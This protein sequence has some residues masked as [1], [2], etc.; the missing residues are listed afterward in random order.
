MVINSAPIPPCQAVLTMDRSW[1]QTIANPAR[2][3]FRLLL[4]AVVPLQLV[5]PRGMEGARAEA[6]QRFEQER[7]TRVIALI[8][9]QDQVNVLGVPVAS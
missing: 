5:G 4:I 6:L 7:N 9:R 2:A 8:H 1:W 3:G